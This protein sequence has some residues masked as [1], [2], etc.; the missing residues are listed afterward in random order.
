MKLPLSWIKEYVEVPSDPDKLAEDLQFSGTKVESLEKESGDLILDFEITPNRSDCY[1]VIGIAREI[2]SLYK[3][4]L[5]LPKVFSEEIQ[6]SKEEPPKLTTENENLCPAYTLGLVDLI[7]VSKS[8]TW[9]IEKLEKSGLRAINNIVDITN[10]V[11]LETGQPMHAFDVSKLKGSLKLRASRDGESI[12]T[13]DNTHRDIPKDSI[14]IEDEDKII[15]LAGLMGG[16]SSEVD[17]TTTTILLHVPIYDP[18]SIRK[19]SQI[20]GLRTEA[21]GRFEK[22]LDPAGHRFAFQRAVELLRIVAGGKLASKI[23]SLGY[24]PDPRFVSFPISLVERVLGINITKEKITEI[25]EGLGFLIKRSSS[26]KKFFEVGVPTWRTDIS[27][28]IDLVE[29]IGRIYGYNNLPKT[30]PSEAVPDQVLAA[31]NF[32]LQIKRI[33]VS[34]GLNEVIGSC[35]TSLKV[36]ADLGIESSSCL[37]VK[38]RLIVDYEYLRPT[39]ILSLLSSIKKNQISKSNL[40]F[41]ETG[42][43]FNSNLGKYGLPDQPKK[44]AVATYGLDFSYVRGYLQFLLGKLNIVGIT[45]DKENVSFFDNPSVQIN[46]KS[47]K[48]GVLGK[49][50]EKNLINSSLVGPI[51][52][53]EIDIETLKKLSNPIVYRSLPKYPVSKENISLFVPDNVTFEIISSII[54][55]GAG[56]NLYKLELLEEGEI[57]KKKSLLLALEYFDKK[58]TLDH[59]EVAKITSRFVQE[60]E[61]VGVQIR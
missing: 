9:I 23:M 45:F 37:R 48:L 1:S 21:S 29:E 54:K 13:L 12:T 42:R 60:L 16:K 3:K 36:I 22:K 20:L 2:S 41:F 27:S 43:V 26:D 14:I 4:V 24:P 32:E 49:I 17:S 47:Q 51:F 19:S 25:L 52:A 59:K 40:V 50:N 5:N 6:T 58:G 38:N 46:V 61:N 28:P 18:V 53:F 7:K 55:K 57:N 33:L 39:L 44:L 8:P 56:D 31:D 10:Y 11:M 30:L 35:L 15:D 34:L